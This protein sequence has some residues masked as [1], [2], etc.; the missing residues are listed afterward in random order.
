V[1]DITF[2]NHLRENKIGFMIKKG[3]GIIPKKTALKE[4]HPQDWNFLYARR[5]GSTRFFRPQ[6]ATL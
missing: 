3:R 6:N 5:S 1:P 4:P 2:Q